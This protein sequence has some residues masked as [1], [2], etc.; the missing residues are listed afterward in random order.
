MDFFEGQNILISTFCDCDDGF[1]GGLSK[2]FY[3]HIRLHTNMFKLSK[4]YPSRDIVPVI[5]VE[6][7]PT[8]PLRSKIRK[9]TYLQTNNSATS[10]KL[11]EM[12]VILRMEPLT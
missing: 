7:L 12:V 11:C 6:S 4:E 5:L 9:R 10:R 2:A 8:T 1:Q 3:F